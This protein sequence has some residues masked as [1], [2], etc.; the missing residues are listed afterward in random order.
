MKSYAPDAIRNVGLFGHGGSGKTTLTEALLYHSGAIGRLGRVDEGTTTSDYDP[1]EV[2][3]KMSVSTAVAPLEWRDTKINLLDTPGYADFFGEV[4]QAMR[5]VECAL[6]VVDAVSGVQVGTDQVWRRADQERLAKIV[7]VNKMERENADYGRVIEQLRAKHGTSVVAMTIPI[8]SEAAFK[9]VVDL[10]SRQAI[11]DDKGGPTDVP[12][13]AE[14]AL[15]R[16]REMLVESAAEIDDDLLTKY[17]EE[18]ELTDEEI[19]GALRRGVAEGR[20]VPVLAGS[21]LQTRG[22]RFLLD[23]LVDYAPPASAAPLRAGEGSP[24][25]GTAALA[26][27]T[28]SD[29]FIGRLSYLRTY[30]GD[31]HSDSHVWNPDKGKEERIGQLFVQRGKQQ[32]P[33]SAIGAGD[34]GVVA[35]LG[36]TSTG[37]TLTTRDHPIVLERI[38]FPEPLY[39]AAVRP[40]TKNDL[41]K[42]SPSLTR[43][44]EED[45]TLS[46]HRDSATGE[47]ILSGL[48]ESHLGIATERMQR[49]FGVS[50]ELAEPHVA[51]RE[52]IRKP[53]KAEGRHVKQSGGHGQYGVCWIEVEP[54]PRGSGFE[55]VD[56]IVGGVV[57]HSYRPAVEKGIREAMEEGVLVGYPVVDIRA[58]LYDGKEHP[59]DSSEMAFKIAGSLAM[60][61]AVQ[62]AGVELLEPIMDVQIEV[63]DDFTGDVISDLN[64]K[65]AHVHGMTPGDGVTTVNAE[66][67]QS[68][69]LHYAADLRALSQGRGTYTMQ[70]ARYD[71]V[72]AHVSQHLVD[73][74]KAEREAAEHK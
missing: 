18:G 4:S 54:L 51:Y 52:T 5:V 29:P 15:N 21:A 16:Y 66:V 12:P 9:G 71:E 55:F 38:H 62:D 72:P 61:K 57:S 35:K 25:E 69:M 49:K 19:R 41:E 48:G 45:P 6:V 39:S 42:L 30:L 37:D 70:F 10:V 22:L 36:E 23:A 28:V 17:L 43:M 44:I 20:I 1:D 60:K 26:F 33:A 64:T 50:V 46:V 58:T 8:G 13:E 68:E 73:K 65:R 59:V 53:A 56:R 63:P 31:I 2:K 74:L 34:I 24:R 14:E 7:F 32:E 11:L 47:M 3:R 27:K 67:P 40:K